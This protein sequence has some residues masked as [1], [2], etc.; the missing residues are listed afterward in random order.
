M[1]APESFAQDRRL[2]GEATGVSSACQARTKR[3]SQIRQTC[4]KIMPAR[5]SRV[6][7]KRSILVMPGFTSFKLAVPRPL[8]RIWGT[9]FGM[10]YLVLQLFAAGGNLVVTRFL[11]P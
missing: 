6:G 5:E 7:T 9:I 10:E 1:P 11:G 2:P 4:D 3:K 8:V